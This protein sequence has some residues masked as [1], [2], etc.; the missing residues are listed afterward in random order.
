MMMIT[1]AEDDD[2]DGNYRRV[3]LF[4][5]LTGGVQIILNVDSSATLPNS[6]SPCLR[7]SPFLL[8]V[9]ATSCCAAADR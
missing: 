9:P 1:W 2:E 7:A 8:G 3:V 4:G 6:S 5:A